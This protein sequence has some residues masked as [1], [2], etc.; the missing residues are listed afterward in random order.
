MTV[1]MVFEY[2]NIATILVLSKCA[3]IGYTLFVIAKLG[4]PINQICGVRWWSHIGK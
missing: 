1:L 3:T 4:G 2:A